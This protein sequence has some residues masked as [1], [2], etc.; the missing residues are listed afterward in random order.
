MKADAH[1]LPPRTRIISTNTLIIAGTRPDVR[2]AIHSHFIQ[3]RA[4][5][6]FIRA[7]FNVAGCVGSILGHF[8]Y[9]AEFFG[10]GYFCSQSATFKVTDQY[11][12]FPTQ[13]DLRLAF[14]FRPDKRLYSIVF[15]I[16]SMPYF[17]FSSTSRGSQMFQ[18]MGATIPLSEMVPFST[19][20][21]ATA[22]GRP[23][24]LAMAE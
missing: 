22:Q 10:A 17:S 18:V 23:T 13:L 15:S 1:N 5:F 3:M 11:L 12:I 14:L 6:C 8:F 20:L 16:N 21:T 9:V 2:S 4:A 19:C 7:S 24:S